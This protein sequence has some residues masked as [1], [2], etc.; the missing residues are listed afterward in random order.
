M[1]FGKGFTP[2][3]FAVERTDWMPAQA[4]PKQFSFTFSLPARTR[5]YV[6]CVKIGGGVGGCATDALASMGIDVV[7]S[8][9]V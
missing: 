9:V 5:Y 4:K 8:G 1:F 2:G 3:T 6:V 7:G